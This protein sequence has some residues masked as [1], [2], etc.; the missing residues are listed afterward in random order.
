LQK[1]PAVPSTSP[2]SG[3]LRTKLIDATLTPHLH[4]RHRIA[5]D[6][7]S[8]N[9]GVGDDGEI[10]MVCHWFQVCVPGV[11]AIA[12]ANIGLNPANAFGVA[13]IVVLIKRNAR[14]LSGL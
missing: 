11:E 13:G 2:Q 6:D 10:F 9:L 8:Q 1:L 5:V 4:S 14:L 7:A 3:F 12:V